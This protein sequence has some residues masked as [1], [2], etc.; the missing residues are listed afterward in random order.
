MRVAAVVVSYN[1]KEL[2]QKTLS[3]LEAQDYPPAGILIVDNAS[4]DGTREYLAEREYKLPTQV[5]RL[6]KNTGG[7]GGFYFGMDKAYGAGYDAF[8]IMDDDTVP[9]ADAL[10]KLVSAMQEAKQAD[11]G[12]A[13]PSFAASMV[14]WK[15]REACEMNYPGAA[16]E[17][18][19]PLAQGYNWFY[20]KCTSF[21][22]CLVTREAVEQCGLPYPEYFI[23]FD[24][25]EYTYRL[26]K[27]RPGIFV[28]D[29]VADH[30]TPRNLGVHW[31]D[32]NSDNLWKY[33]RGAR[34]QVATAF[35]L[36]KLE[37]LAGF[38]QNFVSQAIHSRMSPKIFCQLAIAALK[39][40]RFAPPRRWPHGVDLEALRKQRERSEAETWFKS[41]KR[42]R[43]LA[44]QYGDE[45]TLAEL[46]EQAK[47]FTYFPQDED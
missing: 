2:L 30:L 1:R 18:I 38:F 15:N 5:W 41:W 23:W 37:I 40:V 21:V 24:D 10:G 4:T 11:P 44:I 46:D 17:W 26:S 27:W 36:R 28:P 13:M 8:W 42:R 29:S 39:G 20:L 7:A 32:A 25:A 12:E 6:Q 43:E 3:A 35:S 31:G 14:L 47:Y 34:N 33:S 19:K 45:Q 22:S 9:R 16:W